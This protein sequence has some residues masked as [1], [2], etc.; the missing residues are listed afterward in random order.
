LGLF[1]SV[2]FCAAAAASAAAVCA[3]F[4]IAL[5]VAP[6]AA[7][8]RAQTRTDADEDDGKADAMAVAPLWRNRLHMAKVDFAFLFAFLRSQRHRLT[9]CARH[10][11]QVDCK[12]VL[13]GRH[14]VGKTSLVDRYLNGEYNA[15]V[16]L[17]ARKRSALLSPFWSLPPPHQSTATIGAAFRCAS[18]SFLFFSLS[19]RLTRRP[20]AT[21]QQRATSHCRCRNCDA[22][23]LGHGWR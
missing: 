13:L 14:S 12:V 3:A 18:L 10:P 5:A 20:L 15:K 7:N 8:A 21:R 9:R 11:A 4:C 19:F 2:S 1:F 22:G 17:S 23:H 16:R 6:L